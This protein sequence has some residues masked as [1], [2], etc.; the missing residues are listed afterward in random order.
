VLY[1]EGK[2][3]EAEVYLE[4]AEQLARDSTDDTARIM[5]AFLY[6]SRGQRGNIDPRILRD[7]PEQVADGDRAYWIA[8][9]YALLGE[10]DHALQWLRRTVALGDVNYPWFQRDK[11]LETLRGDKEY[12]TIM[13]GARRR[14][15][16]YKG[17]F[18]AGR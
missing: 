2:L 18:D 7:R 10:R 13:A 17:E 4:R 1:Y 5:A 14:W 15:E 16:A 3:G 11:N 8:G 9:T 6:A 12:Q